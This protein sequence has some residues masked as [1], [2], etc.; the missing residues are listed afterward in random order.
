MVL[1]SISEISSPKQETNKP[2]YEK[3]AFCI[4]KNKGAFVFATNKGAFVFTT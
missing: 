1:V 2:R 3:I 4:C